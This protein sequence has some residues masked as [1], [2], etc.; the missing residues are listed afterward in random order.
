MLFFLSLFCISAVLLCVKLGLRIFFSGARIAG[1]LML[2]PLRIFLSVLA[3]TVVLA[4]MAVF[5]FIL[6]L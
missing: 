3:F 6:I 5:F 1:K 2:L 4:L